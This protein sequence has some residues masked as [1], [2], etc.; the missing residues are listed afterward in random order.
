MVSNRL[1]EVCTRKIEGTLDNGKAL[2]FD[3]VGSRM[4]QIGDKHIF[5]TGGRKNP[6]SCI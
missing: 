5:V 3:D 4:V 6:T 1:H 2:Y